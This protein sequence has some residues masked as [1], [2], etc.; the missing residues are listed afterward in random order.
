MLSL[1]K[2]VKG[3]GVYRSIKFIKVS[4]CFLPTLNQAVNLCCRYTIIAA[5]ARD[6][7]TFSLIVYFSP[8]LAS[9]PAATEQANYPSKLY[10]S[11]LA[12]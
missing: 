3:Q 9:N 1:Q 7:A 11:K 12:A 10:S 6:L 5:I 8:S 4:S 2:N